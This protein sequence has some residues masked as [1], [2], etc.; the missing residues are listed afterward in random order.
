MMLGLASIGCWDNSTRGLD[1]G[2]AVDFVE[3]LRISADIIGT[4]HAVAIYQASEA[5]F[6]IFD[7]AIVLYEGREIFFGPRKSAK[8]YFE[9]MGWY[10]PPRQTTPDFLISVTNP[11]TRKPSQGFRNRVPRTSQDFERYWHGSAEYKALQM[12]IE[13]YEN[14]IQHLNASGEF[15]AARKVAQSR[16][17][18]HKSPYTVSGPTQLRICMKRGWQRLRHDKAPILT[19]LMGQI[20]L[21]LIVGSVFYGTPDNTDSFFATSSTLFFA[22]LLSALISITEVNS[23]DGQRRI[24]EKHASYA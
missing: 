15:K 8:A 13:S 3:A 24:V 14:E 9:K 7:K 6:D 22:I 5:I 1:A 19:A 23:F 17:I 16:Y 18:R 10:C 21:A 12:D 20:I 4:T 11:R 2:T